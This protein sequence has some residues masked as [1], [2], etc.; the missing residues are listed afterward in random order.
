MRPFRLADAARLQA[1]AAGASA[2]GMRRFPD[3]APDLAG[4]RRSLARHRDYWRSGRSLEYGIFTRSGAD[5]LGAVTLEPDWGGLEF[6][7]SLWLKPAARGKG[8]ATEAA[9]LVTEA[10][11]RALGARAVEMGVD[12]GNERSRRVAERLGYAPAGTPEDARALPGAR[13]IFRAT[14]EAW[15]PP[16]G[17]AVAVDRP[18]SRGM[19]TPVRGEP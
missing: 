13:Q 14:R 8:Y 18:R 9:A 5:L 11:F 1:A 2:E 17:V 10:A 12:P 6:A 16:A 19:R 3:A 7:L 15:V 4:T